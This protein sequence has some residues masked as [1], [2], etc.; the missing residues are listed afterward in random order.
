MK[1]ETLARQSVI[2]QAEQRPIWRE[3]DSRESL[4]SMFFGEVDEFFEEYQI[5]LIGGSATPLALEAGDVWISYHRYEFAEG[6]PDEAMSKQFENVAAV[7]ETA[8][9][10]IVEGALAKLLRNEWKYPSQPHNSNGFDH[11]EYTLLGKAFYSYM[12]G[13]EAFSHALMMVAE[14][15]WSDND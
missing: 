15:L 9:I 4:R 3:H 13:D 12:G 11:H 14:D 6:E 10:N 2:R 8:G 1:K 7:C 5:A